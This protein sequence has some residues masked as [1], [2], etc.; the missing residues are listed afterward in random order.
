[1]FDWLQLISR[2]WSDKRDL[3]IEATTRIRTL[4]CGG[5]RN[6]INLC[7]NSFVSLVAKT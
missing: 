6:P 5:E 2:I 3:L 7:T 4:L 1:M